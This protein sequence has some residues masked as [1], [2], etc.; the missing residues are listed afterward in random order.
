MF[1]DIFNYFFMLNVFCMLLSDNNSICMC[2]S[3]GFI[4]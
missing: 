1:N 4:S 2:W 3:I